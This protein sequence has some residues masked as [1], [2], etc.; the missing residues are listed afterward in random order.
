MDV[1]ITPR[2]EVK[3]AWQKMA[4][5][6]LPRTSRPS[7]NT[8]QVIDLGETVLFAFRGRA[9]VL[10]PLAFKKGHELLD[11]WLKAQEF[12]SSVERSRLP[13]YRKLVAR[14]AVMIW[15]CCY[16]AGRGWRM[17]RALGLL[18][19]PFNNASEGE[20]AELAVFILGRRMSVGVLHPKVGVKAVR[21]TSSTN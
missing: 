3:K 12:G 11:V 21:L 17:M 5:E 6:E 18:R 7:L 19:N 10:P 9:Y 20:L 16:P 1:R 15:R 13:E 4:S 14:L 2:E 8:R